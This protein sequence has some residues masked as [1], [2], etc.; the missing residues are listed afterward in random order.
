MPTLR[1]YR[2]LFGAA[3]RLAAGDR[4]YFSAENEREAQAQG[5]EKEGGSAGARA[6]VAPARPAAEA[7]PVPTGA[8]LASG[9]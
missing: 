5:V 6:S 3:P 4:G 7:A 2:A 8:A 1:Q 9:P